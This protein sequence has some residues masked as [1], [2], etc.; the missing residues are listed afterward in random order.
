MDAAGGAPGLAK[1]NARTDVRR[2]RRALADEEIMRLLLAAMQGPVKYGM[3]GSQRALL[4]LRFGCRGRPPR[5]SGRPGR[6]CSLQMSGTATKG[7]AVPFDDRNSWH[8]K[9]L[10]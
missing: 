6:E 8:A 1:L 7:I 4:Y 5:A 3:P 10:A 9:A 2:R